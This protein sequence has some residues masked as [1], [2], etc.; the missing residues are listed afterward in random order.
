MQI[1]QKMRARNILMSTPLE[2]LPNGGVAAIRLETVDDVL[3][4][5][6]G[7][8]SYLRHEMN[9]HSDTQDELDALQRD[10]KAAGRLFGIITQVG[11]A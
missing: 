3:T 10:L 1:D 7:I 2:A 11:Q 4:C 6:D 5:L 9:K 8:V